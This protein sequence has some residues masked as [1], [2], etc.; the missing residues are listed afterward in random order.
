MGEDMGKYMVGISSSNDL[1]PYEHSNQAF[2]LTKHLAI[3]KVKESHGFLKNKISKGDFSV[4]ECPM[5][6]KLHSK[7]QLCKNT[8][9]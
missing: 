4:V 2:E 3:A 9:L 8:F 6:W 5:N 7:E 1:L